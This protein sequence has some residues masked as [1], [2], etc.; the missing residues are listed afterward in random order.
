MMLSPETPEIDVVIPTRDRPD[1]LWACLDALGRQNFE[2]FGVIVV[3]D[4]GREPAE[5]LVPEA[6]RRRITVRFIRNGESIGPGPSRNRGVAASVAPFVVFL[7]DDCIAVPDLLGCHRAGL[8][9]GPVV[10]LGPILSPPGRRLPVWTH[11]DADRLTREYI[12][13]SRGE[14]SPRWSHLY[15]GNVGVRRSDFE[16]VGGF[17]RRFAR[18]EDVE[19][20]YRLARL[21][22]VFR[23]DPAAVVWHVSERSLRGWTRIPAAS[24]KFDVLMDALLPDSARLAE[25]REELGRK[26]WALRVTRQLTRPPLV[27]RGAVD[28]AIGAGCVLHAVHADRAALAAFSVVWDLT[29]SRALEEATSASN[30]VKVRR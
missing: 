29:Y 26:H 28:A 22:C 19:L 25:T 21:G 3:D 12:R 17:D 11:W 24:A 18:Q 9:K 30:S 23:F 5:T 6:I 2:R 8:A 27:R 10:S 7:D 15:T 14:I 13:L 20:G 16:S 4:G 1:Q